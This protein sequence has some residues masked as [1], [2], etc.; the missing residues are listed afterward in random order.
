MK[1]QLRMVEFVD[2]ALPTLLAHMVDKMEGET[3]DGIVKI[4]W[5]GTVI[6]VDFKPHS[7]SLVVT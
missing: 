1:N 6:R 3:L 7:K 4:Y 5:C 2:R